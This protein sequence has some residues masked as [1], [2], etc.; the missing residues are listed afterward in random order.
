MKILYNS[1]AKAK[2][3][4]RMSLLRHPEL[5][6]SRNFLSMTAPSSPPPPRSATLVSSSTPPSH[7]DPTPTTSPKTAF[8]HLKNIAR[9]RPSLSFDTTNTLIHALITDR[10]DYCNSILYGSPNTVLN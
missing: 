3:L 1:R 2:Q 4:I 9:L 5:L 10:L 7:S 6:A 8:F